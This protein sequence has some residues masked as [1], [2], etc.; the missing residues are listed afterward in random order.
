M[1]NE[2][3]NLIIEWDDGIIVIFSLINAKRLLTPPS[4]YYLIYFWT[5]T[6]LVLKHNLYKI[7]QSNQTINLCDWY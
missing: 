4:W 5:F 3:F 6:N 1:I 7:I 2:S